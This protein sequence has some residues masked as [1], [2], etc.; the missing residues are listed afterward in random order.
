MFAGSDAVPR[1]LLVA[2]AIPALCSA[3]SVA[4]ASSIVGGL[5]RQTASSAGLAGRSSAPLGGIDAA[6][7]PGRG[8]KARLGSAFMGGLTMGTEY[9][10]LSGVTVKS[11]SSGEEVGFSSMLPRIARG[12]LCPFPYG[13]YDHDHDHDHV[14]PHL[15]FCYQEQVVNTTTLASVETRRGMGETLTRQMAGTPHVHLE[16]EWQGPRRHAHAL[17][18]PDQLGG[19]IPISSS[20]SSG[21][22]SSRASTVSLTR[23][24]K[25]LYSHRTWRRRLLCGACPEAAV[26]LAHSSCITWNECWQADASRCLT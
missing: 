2:S 10:Q 15:H 4:P 21:R 8:G 20:F 16:Q 9:D 5:R 13:H 19:G 3:F 17:G 22:R 1:L 7:A 26:Q 12:V 11:L 25:W 14:D 24:S 18:R 6:A 23:A